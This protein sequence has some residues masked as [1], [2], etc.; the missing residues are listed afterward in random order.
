MKTFIPLRKAI[1]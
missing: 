1:I